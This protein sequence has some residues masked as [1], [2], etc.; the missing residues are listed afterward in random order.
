MTQEKLI[1]MANQIAV[2][3]ATQPGDAGAVGVATHIND[4]WAPPM[5]RDLLA[6]I[7]A[8]GAGLDPLVLQ[9]AASIR[10]PRSAA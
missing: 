1:R 6:H 7:G 9:A 10:A 3:F 4:N 2:F 8:G 5:R